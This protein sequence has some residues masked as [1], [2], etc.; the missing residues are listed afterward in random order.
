MDI[1]SSLC[2]TNGTMTSANQWSFHLVMIL[3]Y[4]T[5]TAFTVAVLSLVVAAK[6]V[7]GTIRFI[8][9]NILVA[10]ISTCFGTSL[11]SLRFI[12]TSINFHFFSNTDVSYN[13]FLAIIAIGG[14]GRSAFMTV[15]AV[16]VVVIMKG[17]NSA[18]KIKYLIISVVVVWTACVAV[19]A[20]LVVPGVIERAPFRC[21]ANL[22]LEPGNEIW[23]FS[24]L[25]FLFFVIIPCTLAT[26]MPV[27]ALCYIRS[28][29]TCE[30][31]SSLKPMLKFVL[32]LLLGNVLGF[33]G[34]FCPLQAH[35]LSK[36]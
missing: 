25:Y 17:S 15:F 14:N 26:V 34:H 24:A 27:Y 13:I 33:F 12:F 3:I 35:S 32:F 23:I 7:R 16:I 19:G 1:N 4:S 10:S 29:L 36:V 20:I 2:S 31:T 21:S 30:N 18:V 22:V 28:N 8:L 9:A 5:I 11:A 6:A